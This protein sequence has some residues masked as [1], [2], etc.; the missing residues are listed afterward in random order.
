MKK[1]TTKSDSRGGAPAAAAGAAA[2]AREARALPE[3]YPGYL[4][5]KAALEAKVAQAQR[6]QA[7]PLPGPLRDAF[8]GAPRRITAGGKVWTFEPVCAWLMAIL[9]RVESPLLDIVRIYREQ[10][11]SA[12]A[13]GEGQ[14][15]GGQA[16][17][18]ARIAA[19]VAK[20]KPSPDASLETVFA[21]L[22][23]V[24][25]CQALLDVDRL[26][27]IHAARQTL[28]KLHPS[29]LAILERACGEH[30]SASF[31]TAL[32]ISPVPSESGGEVFST[33]PPAPKTASAGGST[34]S[35]P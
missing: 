22:T 14:G 8:A 18:Q 13:G 27:F 3:P 33:P 7:A 35:A 29:D 34:S 20:L 12:D 21:F 16:T 17:I 15:E 2:A 30:F 5:E 19:E 9:V 4:A 10:L 26:D 24:E 28:G 6:A 31:T 1:A 32:S 23:P 25:E 11:A